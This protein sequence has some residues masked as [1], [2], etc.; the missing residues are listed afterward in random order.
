M[1]R[2]IRMSS[3]IEQFGKYPVAVRS[4]KGQRIAHYE[5]FPPTIAVPENGS[6]W[7][8]RELVVLH[9][10]AHHYSKGAAHSP[11]FVSTMTT[12]LGLVMGPEMALLSRIVYDQNDVV[13]G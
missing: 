8:L 13:S 9:E 10:L 7:A 2:V 5:S 4:R 3:V 6:R 11:V 12:L 1:N